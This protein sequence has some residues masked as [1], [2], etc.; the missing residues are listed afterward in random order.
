[1]SRKA[2]AEHSRKQRAMAPEHPICAPCGNKA[3]AEGELL[4]ANSSCAS[5]PDAGGP[6]AIVAAAPA[7]TH[8]SPV[9]IES[10]LDTL[11]GAP[12]PLPLWE[13]GQ[14]KAQASSP[15][16]AGYMRSGKTSCAAQMGDLYQRGELTPGAP[17]DT[18]P[19][20]TDTNPPS[21]DTNPPSTD[22]NPPSTDTNP[23]S[24]PENA[25]V[26]AAEEAVR[27]AGLSADGSRPSRGEP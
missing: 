25:S 5:V 23:P 24:T 2:R 6:A 4:S 13:K 7:P 15:A 3:C 21:T 16:A 10:A 27:A 9:A 11:P 14:R 26:A 8:E 1:M 18:M 22:T 20:R 19:L 17:H 12:A